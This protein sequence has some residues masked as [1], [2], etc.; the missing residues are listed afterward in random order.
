MK[1]RPDLWRG[2]ERLDVLGMVRRLSEVEGIDLV[3]FNYPQHIDGRKPKAVTG[4]LRAAGVAA[5]AVAVRFPA[6]R[7]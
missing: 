7:F 2:R 1:E 5:G 4:A 3:D 6:S